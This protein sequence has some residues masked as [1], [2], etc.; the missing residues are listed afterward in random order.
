MS[1]RKKEFKSFLAI[2]GLLLCF[3]LV[4][5]AMHYVKTPEFINSMEILFGQN[6]V[7]KWNW[8]P[9]KSSNIRWFGEIKA[10]KFIK[11]ED[12]CM[13]RLEILPMEYA[14]RKFTPLLAVSSDDK[15]KTLEVDQEMEVFRVDGFIFRMSGLS[16]RLKSL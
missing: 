14:N 11:L 16:T 1:S 13:A 8:C 10:S 5:I 2:L 6:E 4:I 9:Q 7:R 12:I 15:E 3:S